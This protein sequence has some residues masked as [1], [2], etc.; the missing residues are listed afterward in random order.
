MLTVLLPPGL[1]SSPSLFASCSCPSQCFTPIKA[2]SL[3]LVLSGVLLYTASSRTR[4]KWPAQEVEELDDDDD[5]LED[6]SLEEMQAD[7]CVVTMPLRDDEVD[8]G[9]GGGGGG[10]CGGRRS[11]N[12]SRDG[13]PSP[14]PKGAR[15]GRDAAAD[16]AARGPTMSVWR[17]ATSR[18][19][20]R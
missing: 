12:S 18:W 13:T 14:R 5:D 6:I 7:V 9:G 2:L 19:M 3:F 20:S 15:G 4:L 1:G 8:F 11:S 10:D 16:E 17:A